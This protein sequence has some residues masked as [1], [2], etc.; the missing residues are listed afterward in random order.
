MDDKALILEIATLKKELPD[1]NISST[2][3]QLIRD[4]FNSLQFDDFLGLDS[5]I[6]ESYPVQYIDHVK[7]YLLTLSNS[8]DF[9][10]LIDKYPS[11]SQI[12]KIYPDED[13][14]NPESFAADYTNMIIQ[15]FNNMS[16]DPDYDDIDSLLNIISV[17]DNEEQ[18]QKLI[19]I[20][21]SY[22][23]NSFT[24]KKDR[25]AILIGLSNVGFE[26]SLA[27]TNQIVENIAHGFIF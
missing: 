2:E 8:G 27:D 12:L 18:K 16:K 26:T 6:V 15:A 23:N 25:I 3:E 9:K 21:V 22:A 11:F 10:T 5:F 7:D 1:G 20:V 4:C 14:L 17:L 19:Q 24:A 13:S